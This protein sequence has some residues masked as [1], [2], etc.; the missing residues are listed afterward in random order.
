MSK[1][2]KKI[3][4]YIG[5]LI[6]FQSSAYAKEARLKDIVISNT[7]GNVIISFK[8]EGAF[9]PEMK[10]AILKGTP[11]TFTFF[12]AL[13]E[14]RRLWIDAKIADIRID[15]M[16][17]YNALKE[18]FM[19]KRSWEIDKV[20]TTQ[21]FDEAQELVAQISNLEFLPSDWLENGKHCQIRLKAKLSTTNLPFYLRRALFFSPPWDFETDWYMLDYHR[22]L[23][24]FRSQSAES[25]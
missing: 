20:W 14:V 11:I 19:I 23:L 17:K 16:I 1:R 5:I 2:F 3:L 12:V 6:L 9:S 18:D 13:Y 22:A 7:A 4:I 8:L 21:S 24:N 25:K 15:H 10:E